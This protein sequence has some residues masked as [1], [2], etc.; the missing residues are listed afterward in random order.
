[1]KRCTRFHGED[2][3]EDEVLG[4]DFEHDDPTRLLGLVRDGLAN[5]LVAQIDPCH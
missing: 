3:E 5:Q 4:E 2:H 1:M